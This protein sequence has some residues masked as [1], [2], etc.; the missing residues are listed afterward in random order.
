MTISV[1]L[2][3]VD[4]AVRAGELAGEVEVVAT[5]DRRLVRDVDELVTFLV[6]VTAGDRPEPRS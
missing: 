2:R 1:V 4:D 6:Q 5:G 3:L